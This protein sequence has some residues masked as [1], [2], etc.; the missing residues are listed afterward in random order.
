[1]LNLIAEEL[2][3]KHLSF[4]VFYEWVVDRDILCGMFRMR[5]QVRSC[6][7]VLNSLKYKHMPET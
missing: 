1:M 4:S 5:K 6:L 3:Q 7:S 2:I